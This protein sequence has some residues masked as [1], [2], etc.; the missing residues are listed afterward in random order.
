MRSRNF[1]LFYSS[2]IAFLM[3]TTLFNPTGLFPQEQS[4]PKAEETPKIQAEDALARG[5]AAQKQGI[6]V[7]ALTWLL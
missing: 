1:A 2:F 7:E 4:P 5:V 3:F 6:I